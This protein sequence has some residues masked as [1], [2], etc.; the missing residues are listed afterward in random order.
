MTPFTTL[1]GVV[2]MPAA[3]SASHSANPRSVMFTIIRSLFFWSAGTRTVWSNHAL[4]RTA[5]PLFRSVARRN[6][7]ARFT[8]HLASR[9]L[10]LSLGR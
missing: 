6:L 2:R 7:D 8:R 9:R 10:S 1:T 4:Q 3:L 5:A